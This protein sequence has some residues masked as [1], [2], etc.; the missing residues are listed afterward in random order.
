MK[1]IGIILSMLLIIFLISCNNDE[2]EIKN[3]KPITIYYVGDSEYR[4]Y[5]PITSEHD[6]KIEDNETYTR[7]TV[8]ELD[9][10]NLPYKD[11]MLN[12]EYYSDEYFKEEYTKDNYINGDDLFLKYDYY[13]IITTMELSF[14]MSVA[15]NSIPFTIPY[16][17]QTYLG[18]YEDAYVALLGGNMVGDAINK[19]YLG[20]LVIYHNSLEQIEV[21]Y[22]CYEKIYLE[23]AYEQGI[24]DDKE[25]KE[26]VNIWYIYYNANDFYNFGHYDESN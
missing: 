16:Y 5:N 25:A 7:V 21:F 13:Y 8:D 18:K 19:E 12:V 20:D 15:I 11:Y 6:V 14:I 1:K 23:E 4:G 24:I 10:N 3:K 2:K 17:I 22:D 9:F 26:I